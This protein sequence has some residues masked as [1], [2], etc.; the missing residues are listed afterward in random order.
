MTNTI[1]KGWTRAAA[2][3]INTAPSPYITEAGVVAVVQPYHIT[4]PGSDLTLA[5]KSVEAYEEWRKWWF[6]APQ[7][8]PKV[9]FTH[10][11]TQLKHAEETQVG[12]TPAPVPA[13]NPFDKPKPVVNPFDKPKSPFDAPKNPF[14]QPKKEQNPWPANKK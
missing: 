1:P 6:D 9:S 4:P 14:D 11:S 2:I 10:N 12:V 8:D 13:V 7:P 3:Q 5:F